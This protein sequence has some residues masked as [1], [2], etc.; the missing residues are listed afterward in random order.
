MGIK[1]T[2][3]PRTFSAR[4]NRFNRFTSVLNALPVPLLAEEDL[5][6][7]DRF[8]WLNK[9]SPEI[10]L[11]PL[12]LKGDLLILPFLKGGREGLQVLSGIIFNQ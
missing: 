10:P 6:S 2:C 7:G 12:S 5:I 9:F 8:N 11:F 1:T 4:Q 3:W